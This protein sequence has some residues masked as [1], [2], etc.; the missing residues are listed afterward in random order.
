MQETYCTSAGLAVINMKLAK[1]TT[2]FLDPYNLEQK[3]LCCHSYS[4]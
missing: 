2:S 4:K 1:T 3:G